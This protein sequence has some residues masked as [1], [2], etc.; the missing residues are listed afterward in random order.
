MTQ[1]LTHFCSMNPMI[2][3]DEKGG[4]EANGEDIMN[5]NKQEK[6]CAF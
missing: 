1:E 4:P 2:F 5:N 6:K 3:V